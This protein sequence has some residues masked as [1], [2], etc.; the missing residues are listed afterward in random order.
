MDFLNQEIEFAQYILRN[1][2]V[3]NAFLDR[4][5]FDLYSNSIQ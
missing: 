5:C 3:R 4:F 2:M 1:N